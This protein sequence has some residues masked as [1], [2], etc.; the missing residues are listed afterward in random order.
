MQT[1]R[2]QNLF[3]LLDEIKSLYFKKPTRRHRGRGL[4]QQP[5]LQMLEREVVGS[6]HNRQNEENSLEEGNP[7]FGL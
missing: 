3:H 7:L 4:L 2:G 1:S 6:M 5:S